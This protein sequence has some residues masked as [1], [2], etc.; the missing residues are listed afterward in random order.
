[1]I[2]LNKKEYRSGKYKT[3]LEEFGFFDDFERAC[4][5]G[6]HILK[7]KKNGSCIYLKYNKCSIHTIRPQA[8][9]EF[10]CTSKQKRFASM[11]K[12]IEKKREDSL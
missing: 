1:M 12:Q 5:Y 9:R 3:Q 11:I 2:N 4:K 6:A 7:Q 8:C 10:F